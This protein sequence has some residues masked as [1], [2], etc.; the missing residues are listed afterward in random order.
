MIKD[1]S[2]LDVKTPSGYGMRPLLDFEKTCYHK[3]IFGHISIF[4]YVCL[5]I[6]IDLFVFC[7]VGFAFSSRIRS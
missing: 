6:F 2:D 3:V 7:L 1:F 5:Y 4:C